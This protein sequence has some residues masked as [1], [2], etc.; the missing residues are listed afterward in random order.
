M[1]IR[2]RLIKAVLF[3]LV[4]PVFLPVVIPVLYVLLI[5]EILKGE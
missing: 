1:I 4:S 3:S 5:K 2:K